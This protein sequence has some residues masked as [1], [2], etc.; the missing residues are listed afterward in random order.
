[1]ASRIWCVSNRSIDFDVGV[2]ASIANTFHC[3]IIAEVMWVREVCK[4]FDHSM[5]TPE[6]IHRY[7]NT[8][9]AT[10]NE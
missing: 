6:L 7:R 10:T 3:I 5:T 1:V 4:V 9:E 2:D 8:G